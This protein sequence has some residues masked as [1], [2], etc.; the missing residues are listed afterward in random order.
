MGGIEM[1]ISSKK[2]VTMSDVTVPESIKFL[3]LAKK[4]MKT[5]IDIA[6]KKINESL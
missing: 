1:V 6:P 2:P 4:P 3:R 5:K